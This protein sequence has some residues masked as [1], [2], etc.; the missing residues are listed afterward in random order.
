MRPD[1]KSAN[2]SFFI[3]TLIFFIL[4]GSCRSSTSTLILYEPS[5]DSPFK[6]TFSYPIAW[7]WDVLSYDLMTANIYPDSRQ[8][9]IWL[10][11]NVN[12]AASPKVAMSDR[13]NLFLSTKTTVS[14]FEILEDKLVRIDGRD[15]RWFITRATDE[16]YI[17]EDIFVLCEDRFYMI[18]IRYPE[19]ESNPQFYEEFQSMVESIKF[20][21]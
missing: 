8:S 9:N 17:S 21:P 10:Y 7:Q 15:A 16:H 19:N 4:L 3:T 14:Q 20:L 18:G 2:K 5:E 11:V 6:I 13:M 12:I 1:M